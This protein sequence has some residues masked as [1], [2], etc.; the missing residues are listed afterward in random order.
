MIK[1]AIK[2]AVDGNDLGFDLAKEAMDEIMRGDATSAQI[3][4][5]LTALRMKGE[6]IEEITACATVMREKCTRLSV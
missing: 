5:F 4:A 3:A 1:E 6:S 2:T